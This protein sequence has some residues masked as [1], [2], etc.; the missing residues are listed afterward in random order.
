MVART[1][2][3]GIWRGVL[4]ENSGR[5]LE[6]GLIPKASLTVGNSKSSAFYEA[7]NTFNL[8]CTYL[9]LKLRLT[10]V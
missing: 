3:R 6:D 9:M 4:V 7:R 8:V 2:D 1:F 10:M 5:V